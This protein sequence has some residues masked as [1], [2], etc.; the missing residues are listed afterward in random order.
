MK[1][2]KRIPEANSFV[3]WVRYLTLS[4]VLIPFVAA[5]VI[6]AAMLA[7]NTQWI[8]AVLMT[9]VAGMAYGYLP[10][11]PGLW[12]HDAPSEK[13]IAYAE[14]LGI[15]LRRGMTKGQV[16]DAISAVTGC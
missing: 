1:T 13:Q 15:A 9:A 8:A 10:R 2:K 14:Q 16:S 12:R 5:A 6:G 4:A 3:A 7:F 11:R